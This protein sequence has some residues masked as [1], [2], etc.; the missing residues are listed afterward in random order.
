MSRRKSDE[1][2]RHGQEIVRYAARTKVLNVETLRVRFPM[3]RATAF[4]RLPQLCDAGY[5]S[6]HETEDRGSYYTA[7]R[8]G[9]AWAE[10]DLAPVNFSLATLSHDMALARI[11]GRLEEAGYPCKSERDMRL[12]ERWEEDGRYI[13]KMRDRGRTVEHFAD[14]A[15][16]NP[17]TGTY[18]AIEVE[19]TRKSRS[20]RLAIL[21]GYEGRIDK[22]GLGG[23]LYLTGENCNPNQ[24]RVSARNIG[25]DNAMT[26]APYDGKLPADALR[27]LMKMAQ[28]RAR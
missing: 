9:I 1:V 14:V 25:L 18:I 21:H 27:K 4:R 24:L 17:R 28:Q 6:H 7:T 20:R 5:L 16:E 26:T 12:H 22:R 11:V 10:L 8:L 2:L 3:S 13:I 15:F 19:L 23:L